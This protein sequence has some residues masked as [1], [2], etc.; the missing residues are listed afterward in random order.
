MAIKNCT[1]PL[2][3]IAIGAILMFGQ[4]ASGMRVSKFKKTAE[5]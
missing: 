5:S 1:L 4:S 3:L 2:A